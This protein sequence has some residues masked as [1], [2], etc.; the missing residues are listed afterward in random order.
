MFLLLKRLVVRTRTEPD[1]GPAMRPSGAFEDWPAA[2]CE[3]LEQ[4]LKGAK[5]I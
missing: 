3:R 1:A 4:I 5:R 2:Y